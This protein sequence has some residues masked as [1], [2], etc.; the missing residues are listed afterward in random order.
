MDRRQFM[1][2]SLTAAGSALLS[3]NP[4]VSPGQ[5]SGTLAPLTNSTRFPDGFLWG[6][7]TASYQVEGAWNED[8]KG[9]SIWDRF[10]HT[11][12]KVKGAATGDIACDQY[13]LYPQDIAILKQ[14]HQ[15]SYRFSISWARIQPSGTGA[16]NQ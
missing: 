15:K 3:A 16:P 1:R 2:G 14:L 6:M 4:S 5:I 10:S 7:A 13:H 11:Q 8:G 12:G 9:E